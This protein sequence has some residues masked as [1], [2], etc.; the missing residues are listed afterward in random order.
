MNLEMILADLARL[1]GNDWPW[2]ALD[3]YIY[4]EVVA[5]RSSLSERQEQ[6]Y[7]LLRSW[8]RSTIEA[9][10]AFQQQAEH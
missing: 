1:H 4:L 2:A 8:L 7:R 9:G 6:E 5:N 3:R 10:I